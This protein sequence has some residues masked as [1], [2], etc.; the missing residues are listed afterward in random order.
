[1]YRSKPYPYPA[2]TKEE[3]KRVRAYATS[4]S[5]RLL[6][7]FKPCM[8]RTGSISNLCKHRQLT[9]GGK[10]KT[11]LPFQSTRGHQPLPWA[12]GQGAPS[13]SPLPAD[14]LLGVIVGGVYHENRESARQDTGRHAAGLHQRHGAEGG[15]R[16]EGL[17][18][19]HATA[20]I[21]E[22]PART[23]TTG[24]AQ[25]NAVRR[26]GDPHG[27]RGDAA[28]LHL[29]HVTARDNGAAST[30]TP[31]PDLIHLNLNRARRLLQS[32]PL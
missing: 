24:L 5:G 27:I 31:R 14:H 22:R 28:G 17:H 2:V 10:Y 21:I 18:Q 9:L 29:G 4:K 13:A 6:G 16:A 8:V 3:E 32:S 7:S 15:H 30:G 19:R 1:M 11:L 26:E 25:W 20:G 12:S 23:G